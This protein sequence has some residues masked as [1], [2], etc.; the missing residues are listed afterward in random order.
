MV[1]LPDS[2]GTPRRGLDWPTAWS[3][4]VPVYGLA[5][6]LHALAPLFAAPVW[7]IFA[8]YA[9]KVL[10]GARRAE[11]PW[12]GRGSPRPYWLSFVVVMIVHLVGAASTLGPGGSALFA[13]A[14]L[15]IALGLAAWLVAATAP[16]GVREA[17]GWLRA[18]VG[19]ELLGA[20]IPAGYVLGNLPATGPLLL[21][22][23]I[24]TML[25]AAVSVLGFGLASRARSGRA[26]S[27]A[28]KVARE[29]T[30]E[31]PRGS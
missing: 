17:R 5:A 21:V 30:R 15:P 27:V 19:A 22:S 18:G 13:V 12:R 26:P 28:R 8:F 9:W 14:T 10:E 31:G 25:L 20:L 11:D 7:F 6:I 1:P 3:A 29:G 16:P 2:V 4:L 23:L 24:A